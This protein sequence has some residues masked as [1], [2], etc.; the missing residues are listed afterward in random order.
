MSESIQTK[1]NANTGIDVA[2]MISQT[3][4]NVKPVDKTNIYSSLQQWEHLQD[5]VTAFF[6]LCA[7]LFIVCT[8]YL[9]STK[10]TNIAWIIAFF[11]NIIFLI[12][13][14]PEA[15]KYSQTGYS[16]YTLVCLIITAIFNF[17]TI[18]LIFIT[19]SIVTQRTEDYH[20]NDLENGIPIDQ[21]KYEP[22][23]KIKDNLHNNRIL[24]TTTVITSIALL[25]N[26]FYDAE[27]RSKRLQETN[28]SSI[29]GQNIHWL[30]GFIPEKLRQFDEFW[31][32]IF[33]GLPI[34]PV[35][36]MFLLFSFGFLMFF[37]VPF[38]RIFQRD[39]TPEELAE[40]NKYPPP[41]RPYLIEP[42]DN[43]PAFFDFS[44]VETSKVFDLTE[45]PKMNYHAFSSFISGIMWAIIVFIIACLVCSIFSLIAKYKWIAGIGGSVITFVLVFI[46]NLLDVN[47]FDNDDKNN[48]SEDINF[49][50]KKKLYF[51]LTFTF[52]L[53][54]FPVVMMIFE[55][56]LRFVLNKSFIDKRRIIP[57]VNIW[58]I[59]LSAAIF[60]TLWLTL[61]DIGNTNH[62][63]TLPNNK[64]VKLL[65]IAC[66]GLFVGWFFAFSPYFY[67]FY[68]IVV[69][70][71]MIIRY[72]LYIFGPIGI[73]GISISDIII[74][75]DSS[76]SRDKVTDGK[77]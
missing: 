42:V 64:D 30:I 5:P 15:F 62:W 71:F 16:I 40:K 67:M 38:T 51:A 43:F 37:L 53:V 73:L 52:G 7:A 1:N 59:G 55:L 14:V 60:L 57:H 47:L 24:F 34:D 48:N 33:K 10:T 20:K 32:S 11:L 6:M 45:H 27:E 3:I 25:F 72:I 18:I 22:S 68:G 50:A 46:L 8:I 36:N 63:Y 31:H 13:W 19:N 21:I 35:L 69:F 54:G 26:F 2:N 76:N 61:Y 70:L 65:I 74:A 4:E 23:K 41:Y 75:S 9:Y 39:L 77:R 49:L 17:A 28:Q 29:F 66:I 44:E 58:M 56:F 12:I